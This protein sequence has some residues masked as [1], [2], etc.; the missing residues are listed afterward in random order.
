M[1]QEIIQTQMNTDEQSE[2][3]KHTPPTLTKSVKKPKTKK[4]TIAL[5]KNQ[6]RYDHIILL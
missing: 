2:S 3:I 4:K 5:K 1:I 6:N